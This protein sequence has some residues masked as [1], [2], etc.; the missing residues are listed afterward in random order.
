MEVDKINLEIQNDSVNAG[1]ISD[2]YHTFNELYE[3]RIILF[4]AFC[5]VIKNRRP[6]WKSKAHSDG[7]VW[8][9][10]FI[11][12]VN[13]RPGKQ[14]TYHLPIDKWDDCHFMELSR[15]P[16]FDGHTS[17]DVLKRISDFSLDN[18]SRYIKSN[19]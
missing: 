5:R 4:I 11:L 3:H 2:G 18:T 15:A 6:V 19:G 14:I 8:D 7:S 9:G 13:D 1:E 12:G 17:A 10:W 16:W